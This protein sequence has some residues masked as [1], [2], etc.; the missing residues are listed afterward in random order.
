MV[1]ILPRLR[2]FRWRKPK[3]Q[4]KIPRTQIQRRRKHP[5]NGR[6]L[7]QIIQAVPKKKTILQCK[8]VFFLVRWAILDLN[9][10]PKDYESSALTAELMARMCKKNNTNGIFRQYL[11]FPSKLL[12]KNTSL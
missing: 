1:L 7:R 11:F 10:G 12:P 8:M 5:N 6:K 9:Q 3:T 2:T 4:R